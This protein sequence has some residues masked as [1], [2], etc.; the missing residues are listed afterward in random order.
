MYGV[1]AGEMRFDES[2]EPLLASMA[3]KHSV[4]SEPPQ[5]ALGARPHL[6]YISRLYLGYISAPPQLALGASGYR[7]DIG[8]T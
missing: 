7:R 1:K 2:R 3:K 5:L 8:E 4:E 6:G